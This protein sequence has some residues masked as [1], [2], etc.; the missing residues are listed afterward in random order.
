VLT[1]AYRLT[2]QTS[3]S[4]RQ[5][6]HLTP[7]ITR[8]RKANTRI[9]P[10]ETITPSTASPGLPNTPE[11]Q[12]VDLKSYLMMLIGDCNRDINNSLKEI[13]EL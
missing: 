12:D 8:W 7:E 6:E 2:G 5:Q 1:H 9:L 3:S 13:Q 10:T 11:N 4:Q